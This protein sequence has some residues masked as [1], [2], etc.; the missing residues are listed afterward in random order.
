[1]DP[2][3]LVNTKDPAVLADLTA[4]AELKP[5]SKA[6]PPFRVDPA[7]L[8]NTKD[9][10]VLVDLAA[11]AN[12]AGRAEVTPISK[13]ALAVPVHQA[14]LGAAKVRANRPS[15]AKTRIC[16][17]ASKSIRRHADDE[18]GIADYSALRTRGSLCRLG[19]SP[20]LLGEGR[21]LP[22]ERKQQ[23]GM[24]ACGT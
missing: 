13:A 4:Q 7:D 22:D 8:V 14:V 10:A 11:Q 16:L 23:H 12:L 2:A 5:I 9:P 21:M 18:K 15:A 17:S 20:P 3:D 24:S 6:A 1:V 19:R